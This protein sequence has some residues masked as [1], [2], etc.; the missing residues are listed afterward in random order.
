M[1]NRFHGRPFDHSALPRDF[2]ATHG[3]DFDV[4]VETVECWIKTPSLADA[5]TIAEFM[6]NVLPLPNPPPRRELQAYVEEHFA[7][8]GGGYRFSCS[9][10]FLQFRRLK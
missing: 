6:L 2:A 10:D 1:L 9:Q 3:H 5:T 4:A 8:P 7:Q